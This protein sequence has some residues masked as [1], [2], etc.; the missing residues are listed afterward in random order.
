V[1]IANDGSDVILSDDFLKSYSYEI[2]YYLAKH[3][4]MSGT[5]NFLLDH[6]TADYIIFCDA[7]DMFFNVIALNTIFSIIT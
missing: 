6:S 7:D 2:V 1:I 5:R 3:R 4:G